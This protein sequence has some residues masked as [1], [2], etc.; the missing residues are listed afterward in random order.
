MTG[1]RRRAGAWTDAE[2]MEET[3]EH[4]AAPREAEHGALAGAGSHQRSTA[5]ARVKRKPLH[6]SIHE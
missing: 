5:D 1:E 4:D 3:V 6:S 2:R